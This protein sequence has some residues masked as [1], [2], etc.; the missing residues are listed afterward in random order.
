MKK[1]IL[2]LTLNL[3]FCSC[4]TAQN[5][6]AFDKVLKIKLTESNRED[7]RKIFADYK[8]RN[9]Y[10]SNYF[11]TNNAEI[12]ISYSKGKCD[13]DE[14][15][16][17][18]DISQGKVTEIKISPTKF[19]KLKK[20][21]SELLKS[22]IDF[23]KFV[24]EKTYNNREEYF[25]YHNKKLGIILSAFQ[26]DIREIYFN[27]T[28]EQYSLMCDKEKAQQLSS[29][30]SIFDIPIEERFQPTGLPAFPGVR[31]LTLSQTEITESC[32][33]IDATDKSSLETSK[34]ITVSTSIINP[35]KDTLEYSYK[36]TGGKIRGTGKKVFWDLSGVKAGTYEIT[37][38]VDDGCGFCGDVQ[39][40]TVAVKECSNS[41]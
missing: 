34:I 17:D 37:A 28:L 20:L 9:I 10:D 13:E 15:S 41:K 5:F 22:G 4:I 16:R 25:V 38:R 21:K 19:V 32:K 18:L 8:T 39:R 33:N 11:Y 24:K 1:T 27:P 7:V 30:E 14:D 23:S 12:E 3:I 36:V 6:L 2:F 35:K 26:D 40:K 31:K 29:T